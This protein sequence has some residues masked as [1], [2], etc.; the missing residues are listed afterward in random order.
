MTQSPI[1]ITTSGSLRREATT[2]GP[3]LLVLGALLLAATQYDARPTA[4]LSASAVVLLGHVLPGAVLW[5]LVRPERGWLVEDLAVGF[6]LGAALSVPGHALAVTVGRPA[7]GILLPVGLAAVALAVPASRQRVLSRHTERLPWLWGAAVSVCALVP[8]LVNWK[9][10]LEPVR[11]RGWTVQYVD[12]PYHTALVHAVSERFP[13]YYPQVA[14]EPLNYHWFAHAWTA[15]VSSVSG[16]DA[17]VL[18]TRFNPSLMA[19][20]V[21]L[22]TAVAAMRVSGRRWAGPVA[23]AVAFLLLDV[24][25]WV[26]GVVLSP[27]GSPM[28]PTQ[29]FGLLVLLTLLTLLVLRWRGEASRAAWPA[30]V[31]LLVV[32]GGSKG[33]LLPVVAAGALVAAAAVLILRDRARLRVVGPD[34]AL[35]VVTLLLLNRLMFGGGNGGVSLDFGES[36]VA[37]R[38]TLMLGREVDIASALGVLILILSVLPM[39]LAVLGGLGLLGAAE[40]RSDPVTWL[41]LGGGV[42]GLGAM[43]AFNHPGSSQHYFYKAG[44]PLLAIVGAWGTAVL[45]ERVGSDRRLLVAGLA[46]GPLALAVTRLLLDRDGPPGA[47][48]ALIALAGLLL[49]VTLGAVVA[50]RTTGAGRSGGLAVAAIALLSAGIVPTT[51]AVAKWDPPEA[52]EATEDTARAVHGRDVRALRWLGAHSERGDLVATNKHCLS[53]VSDPCDRRRF[54]VA[55]HTGRSVLVEGWSYNRR[56]APLYPDYGSALFRDDQ[57]WDL[58]LMALN[59]G[60][61]A[62]PTAAGASGLWDL[63]VRWIVVWR[64]AP[65]ADDLAP[66]AERVRRGLAVEVYRLNP[67][68]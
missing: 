64:D 54:F 25:P 20:A 26:T 2:L 31:L 32:A 11:F 65:H 30:L 24:K 52:V 50:A 37:G 14:Q 60:F 51:V 27:M 16:V 46:T 29:Q 45:W 1:V 10:F 66:Y 19:V 35:A 57:F 6:G 49:L 43:V 62:A 40:T 44:E 15:Q 18:L 42:V 5:R 39:L 41:L 55:A 4:L 67:P 47:D 22:V 3:P 61:I 59:D 9:A 21:P 23:A 48:G 58:E 28:S 12:L 63:G 56:A 13:P 7:L 34:A 53:R 68:E 17:V 33:S 38:G 8:T 36:Y